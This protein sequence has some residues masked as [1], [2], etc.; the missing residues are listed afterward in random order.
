MNFYKNSVR[1]GSGF[2]VA[3]LLTLQACSPNN[4]TI[5]NDYK[6]YFD[7]TQTTGSFGQ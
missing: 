1:V 3:I 2:L 7:E 5:Q 6:Q 4:V